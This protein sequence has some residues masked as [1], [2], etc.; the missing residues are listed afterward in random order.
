MFQDF[1]M[2]VICDF[3]KRRAAEN[4]ALTH[5]QVINEPHGSKSLLVILAYSISASYKVYGR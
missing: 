2:F 5:N 1:A 4:P 3:T